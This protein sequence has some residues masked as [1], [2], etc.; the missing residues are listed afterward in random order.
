MRDD[1]DEDGPRSAP[2]VPPPP[3]EDDVYDAATRVGGLTPEALAML[4]QL[5]DE[6]P[7]G[8]SMGDLN[9]PVF[10]ED[11]LESQAKPSAVRPAA[12]APAPSPAA[13]EPKA[14][15]PATA[16]APEPAVTKEPKPVSANLKPSPAE[17]TPKVAPVAPVDETLPAGSPLVVSPKLAAARPKDS[18]PPLVAPGT[19]P[20]AEPEHYDSV[21]APLPP[22][23][24]NP[25]VGGADTDAVA[26]GVS[27]SLWP[28][29]LIGALVILAAAALGYTL[30][31]NNSPVPH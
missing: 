15:A 26:Q 28:L 23:T 22:S 10:V 2:T 1:D 9:L 16:K 21:F 13:T 17:T 31:F 24:A 3:G 29:W 25:G 27:T 14:A 5:R 8:A 18:V 11:E 19:V 30:F 4:K 12:G 20:S 7:L 6:K